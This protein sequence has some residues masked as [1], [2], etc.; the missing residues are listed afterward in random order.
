[1]LLLFAD[2]AD[3]ARHDASQLPELPSNVV[4]G[5]DNAEGSIAASLVESLRLPASDRPIFIIADTFNRVVFMTQGYTIG[6]GDR[7]IDT[8]HKLK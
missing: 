3:A 7:L 4:V 8:I 6:L 5:T 1:M 2:A